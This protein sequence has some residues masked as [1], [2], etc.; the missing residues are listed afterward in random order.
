MTNLPVQQRAPREQFIHATGGG[1]RQWLG[2]DNPQGTDAHLLKLLLHHIKLLDG[3]LRDIDLTVVRGTATSAGTSTTSTISHVS[4]VLLGVCGAIP[5]VQHSSRGCS[6]K[7][8]E[9]GAW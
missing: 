8:G 3:H 6:S 9:T 2:A 5:T 1:L 4:W 7:R